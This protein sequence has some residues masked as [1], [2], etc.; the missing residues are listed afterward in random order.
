M[1]V[2]NGQKSVLVLGNDSHFGT[3]QLAAA[4]SVVGKTSV[5]HRYTLNNTT[6][7]VHC[8]KYSIEGKNRNIAKIT[9]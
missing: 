2:F 9:K 7:I 3:I 4:T 8:T 5:A 1:K 6:C